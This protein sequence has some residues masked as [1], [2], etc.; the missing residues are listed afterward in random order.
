MV[1]AYVSP[2]LK[3][4][5]EQVSTNVGDTPLMFMQSNGGLTDARFFR[6][7]IVSYL[8]QR[9]AS[10]ARLRPLRWP[11]SRKLLVL[12]WAARPQMSPIIMVFMR[13]HSKH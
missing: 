11:V 7:R 8:A 3:R 10:L 5:V 12:I 1:D 2:I 9:A 13:E 4:Y 6:E